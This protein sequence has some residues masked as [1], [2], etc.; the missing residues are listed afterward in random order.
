MIDPGSVENCPFRAIHT[1]RKYVL[2]VSRLPIPTTSDLWTAGCTDYTAVGPLRHC[3]RLYA[4][5]TEN[6]C[7]AADIFN[8]TRLLQWT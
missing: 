7:L 6:K 5:L 2:P 8:L 4:S 1:F 3:R